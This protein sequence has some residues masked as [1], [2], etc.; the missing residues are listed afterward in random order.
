MADENK[1]LKQLKVKLIK[2]VIGAHRKH[3]ACVKTLGLRRINH[4]VAVV[5]CPTIRGMIK[6]IN[7]LLSVEEM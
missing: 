6:K 2:S 7:Y 5:D 1:Q 4:S 3:K